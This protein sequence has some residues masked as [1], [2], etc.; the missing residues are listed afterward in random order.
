[1][2]SSTELNRREIQEYYTFIRFPGDVRCEFALKPLRLLFVLIS[3]LLAVVVRI[4]ISPHFAF[5]VWRVY[6][7]PVRHK[8]EMN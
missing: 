8:F 7:I 3:K 1:M 2:P 4:E 5:R 6:Y